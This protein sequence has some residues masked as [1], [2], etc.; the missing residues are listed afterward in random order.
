M[1]IAVSFSGMAHVHVIVALALIVL[2]CT[3]ARPPQAPQTWRGDKTG[4]VY[5]E[6]GTGYVEDTATGQ[7]YPRVEQSWLAGERGHLMYLYEGYVEE[8][9]QWQK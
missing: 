6:A 7:V 8:P 1:M 3:Y 9:Q 2:G 5:Q 4:H